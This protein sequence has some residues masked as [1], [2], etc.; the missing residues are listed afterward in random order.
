MAIGRWLSVTL[1]VRENVEGIVINRFGTLESLDCAPVNDLIWRGFVAVC[2]R[3]D[4]EPPRGAELDV[5]SDIPVAR[6]LG[7]SAAAVVAGGL[8][9]NAYC[10][11]KLDDAAIID[12]A[13]SIE[14]HPDNVAPSTL[15]GAVLSVRDTAGQYRSAP[16][17]IHPSLRFVFLVPDFEVRTSV[18]RAALPSAIAYATAVTAT[19]RSAALIIGLQTANAAILATALDDVLHVPFRRAL[20]RGY[21]EVTTAAIGAGA[22]GATLSGSGSTIVAVTRKATADLVCESALRAWKSLDVRAEGFVTAAELRSA[23]IGKISKRHSSD[24]STLKSRKA[25][26]Q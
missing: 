8:L 17:A 16:I 12:I 9:A 7:S 2:A 4:C 6:G 22:I 11:G 21:D 14:G 25:T 26:W 18:A 15:G 13:A 10:D 19:A 24:G 23:K 20:I 1:R 3:L 5:I